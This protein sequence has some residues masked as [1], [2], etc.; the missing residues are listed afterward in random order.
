MLLHLEKICDEYY[1]ALITG[2]VGRRIEW[3]V[4]MHI[5]IGAAE[6]EYCINGDKG[7]SMAELTRIRQSYREYILNCS[8]HYPAGVSRLAM[9]TIFWRPEDMFCLES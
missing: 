5:A 4:V 8:P 2:N 7:A 1:Q 9:V 3:H 6:S